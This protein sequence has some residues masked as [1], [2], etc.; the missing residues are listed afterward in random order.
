M[1][2]PMVCGNSSDAGLVT[3]AASDTN[4]MWIKTMMTNADEDL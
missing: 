1:M 4:A 3:A 2:D